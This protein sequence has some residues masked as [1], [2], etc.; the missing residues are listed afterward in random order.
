ML[1]GMSLKN[2]KYSETIDH[3]LIKKFLYDNLPLVNQVKSIEQEIKIGNRI[4]DIYLE[5]ENGKKIVIEIQHSKI[6]KLDLIQRTKE[7][8]QEGIHVMWILDGQGP[9]DRSPKNTDGV[10]ISVSEKELHSLYRGRVYYINAADDGISTAVYALHFTPYIE[11]KRSMFGAEY[12]KISKYKKSVVCGQISS[13]QLTLFRNK[14]FK[15]ACFSDQSIKTLCIFE[16]VEFLSA[17]K[18]YRHKKPNDIK[19]RFPDGLP[20]GLLVKRFSARYGLYLLFDV[21]RYLKLLTVR[22]AGYMFEKEL[23][24][25]KYISV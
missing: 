1:I 13:L 23:L 12:Y 14:G 15:L 11:R 18:A 17:F 20:L 3:L 19:K 7:Y 22:D 2:K 24:S 25:L 21:L 4:A 16:V 10:I 9:Y 6:N 5:L 8:N